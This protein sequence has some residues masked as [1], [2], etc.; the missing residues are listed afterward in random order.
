MQVIR[1]NVV[2][3]DDD[4]TGLEWSIDDVDNLATLI[5]V[6]ALGQARRAALGALGSSAQ[7]EDGR[8][9]ARVQSDTGAN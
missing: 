3:V 8:T 6:I 2:P 9:L 1:S 4:I 7:L 5:A